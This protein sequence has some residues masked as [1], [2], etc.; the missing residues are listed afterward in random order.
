MKEYAESFYKGAAW[1]RCRRGFIRNR[2]MIDGG[3]CQEC[4]ER[5]GVIVHHRVPITPETINDPYITL[6][7]RNL[8]YVCHRCHDEIH[9]RT[10]RLPAGMVRY[11]FTTDGEIAI[12]SD[13]PVI[14]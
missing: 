9:D 7:W 1:Q 4:G 12:R 5:P 6:D 11:E 2:Q 13:P 3:M 8:E 10:S 14:A